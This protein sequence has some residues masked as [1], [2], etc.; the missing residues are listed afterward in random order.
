MYTKSSAATLFHMY[1]NY[2]LSISDTSIKS[3]VQPQFKM[4]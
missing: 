1:Y 3:M 2:A 4:I